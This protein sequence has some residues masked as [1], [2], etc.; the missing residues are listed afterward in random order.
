MGGFQLRKCVGAQV[1]KCEFSSQPCKDLQT[2]MKTSAKKLRKL[3]SGLRRTSLYD[4][5]GGKIWGTFLCVNRKSVM[6]VMTF[7]SESFSGLWVICAYASYYMCPVNAMLTCSRC[8]Y[9][10]STNLV[11]QKIYLSLPLSPYRY[12]SI[13][14]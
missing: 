11:K 9:Y 4:W 7:Y 12:I 2:V 3:W 1:P 8:M 10:A 14:I 6:T 5:L 13:S